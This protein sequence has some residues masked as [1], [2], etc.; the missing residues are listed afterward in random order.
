MTL[1]GDN[2]P[3]FG[4]ESVHMKKTQTSVVLDERGL[5]TGFLQH[6]ETFGTIRTEKTDDGILIVTLNRPD[7]LNAFDEQMIRE[8][9]S[10]VWK[11]NFDDAIRVII[12]TGEGRAFCS[13][14]D[15]LRR[16]ATAPMSVPITNCSTRS[17]R[18]RSQSSRL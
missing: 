2:P 5:P 11:A 18:S 4:N 13:G 1:S 17:R 14:R 3:V 6:V 7:K 12:I 8:M 16:R 15:I 9:R 10:V